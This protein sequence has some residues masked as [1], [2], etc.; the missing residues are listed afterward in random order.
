MKNIGII[1]NN[2]NKR[3]LSIAKEI[4]DFLIGKKIDVFLLDG[5]KLPGIYKLPANLEKDFT[6]H[7]DLLISVGGD[8]TFLRASKYSF[9]REIPIMG[10]NVGNLGFL[11]E[12]SIENMYKALE[13][14]LEETYE[15][16]DRM[17]IEAVIYRNEKIISD[18]NN[19]YIALNEFTINRTMFT[20]LITVEVIINDFPVMNFRADGV[21]I[22]TPTGST[23]YS[24]S[25]GGPVVE[26]KNEVLIVTPICAHT[27]CS[28]SIVISPKNELKVR[29]NAR[30][31][32]ASLNVDGVRKNVDMQPEDIFKIKK[33][34]LKLKLIT[35]DKDIFFKIF[36]D[37]LL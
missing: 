5:D 36:K 18:A 2:K 7:V 20:K 17:L 8:G 1:S 11:A 3:A 6:S 25:A 15:I 32:N 19:P 34:N 13:Y 4:Y 30:N 23:A 16:E 28:R 9:K 26:P 31:K 27:L 10:I 35:F 37:K 22:S 24:L 33:S 14:V 29:I 12:V 21:I